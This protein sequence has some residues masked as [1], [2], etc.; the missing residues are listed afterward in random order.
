M[1]DYFTITDTLYSITDRYP[2]TIAVFASNGFPQMKDAAQRETFGKMITFEAA[3]R[4]KDRHPQTFMQLLNEVIS[5]E[6]DGADATLTQS[7]QTDEHPLNV[8]GLLPCP[9]RLPLLEQ[10]N[11]FASTNGLT[12]VNTELKAASVGTQWVQENLDGI[13]KASQL[14]DLFL[15]A[16]FDLFFDLKKIGR[17]RHQGIFK[18]LVRHHDENPLFRGRGLRDPSGSYSLISV[19]PAIFLVNTEELGDR[20]PPRSWADLLEPEWEESV[21]LP[22][23][24]FDLFNAILL[25]IDNHY[26]EKG[27]KQLGRAMLQALHPAQ[28]VRSNRLKERRPAV[29]IMPYFFTKTARVGGAME[30]LWPEDGAIISPIF[31]LAKKARATELQPL[32]DFFAS[33]E[34]GETLAHQGLFP[35]LHPEVNNNLADD[36]PMM[37]LGWDKILATDLSAEIE[38]CEALFAASASKGRP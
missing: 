2:E 22:V 11:A 17:F 36:T 32:V 23:G 30:A 35:S 5:T 7:T 19:V 14:P 1:A 31:M 37:W 33:R 34:V 6:R 20:L 25:N 29:T 28:M 10:Y 16:G 9:V 3:L 15:S 4:M 27:V 21:A 18:D 26:G 8:V 12:R 13:T 24:D 38:R